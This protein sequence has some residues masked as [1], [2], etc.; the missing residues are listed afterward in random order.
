MCSQEALIFWKNAIYI[1]QNL[2]KDTNDN[3][4]VFRGH[5]SGK[6]FVFPS[7]GVTSSVSDNEMDGS[8][9]LHHCGLHNNCSLTNE[10]WHINNHFIEVAPYTIMCLILLFLVLLIID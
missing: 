5:S 7:F 4:Y 3:Q 10:I 6:K 8:H 2:H 1:M 9:H